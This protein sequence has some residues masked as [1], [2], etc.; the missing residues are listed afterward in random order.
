MEPDCIEG[1]PEYTDT[2]KCN[3]PDC[4]HTSVIPSV[5]IIFSQLFS[6]ITGSGISLYLLIIHLTELL[7]VKGTPP[8][9]FLV[10][11]VMLMLLA[12][13]F[14]ACFGYLFYKAVEGITLRRHFK[15]ITR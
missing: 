7:L 1:E 2:F 12:L 10:H 9:A 4:G 15:K 13:G 6:A 14:I 3:N 8:S 11:H 5:V